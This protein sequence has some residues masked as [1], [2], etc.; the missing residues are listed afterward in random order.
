LFEAN[1]DPE[2]ELRQF[3]RAA[4]IPAKPPGAHLMLFAIGSGPGPTVERIN[5][6]PR[7]G[8]PA[9]FRFQCQGWGLIQLDFGSF[10]QELELRWSHTN[11]NTSKRAAKWSEV[12]PQ[13]G[14]P[15]DWDWS[16][17]TRASGRLNRAIRSLAVD[18]IGPHPVLP[19][20]VQ[21]IHGK[22]LS[23]EYGTGIHVDMS[24]GMARTHG[25]TP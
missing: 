13:L 12:Y 20:A 1:S 9:S 25:E 2:Q 18:R 22:D 23:Y 19:A 7:A 21:L 14:D 16:A 10:F 11:H 15:G 5:L 3:V 17:V 24:P 6:K 4:D 8:S